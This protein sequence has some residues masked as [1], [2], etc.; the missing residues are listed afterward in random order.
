MSTT[1]AVE[2]FSKLKAM[3]NT[4]SIEGDRPWDVVVDPTTASYIEQQVVAKGFN[5]ADLALKNGFA[6]D[7]LG[8]KV[9]VSNNILH[10]TLMTATKNVVADD[11]VIVG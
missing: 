11:A 2:V 5:T 10:K 3:M 1:N 7:F 6:G 8:W 9:H 4:H